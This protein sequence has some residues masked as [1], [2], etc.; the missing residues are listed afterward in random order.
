MP[1]VTPDPGP[2]PGKDSRDEPAPDLSVLIPVYNEAEN[3]GPLHDELTAVL[4][5]LPLRYELIFVDD[6]SSDG[7]SARLAGIQD[8][9]PERVRVAFLRR[10]YGQ[11]AA[12]SA[13]LDLARGDVLVPMDGDRQ[14]DP[15][16]IPRLLDRL[17]QGCE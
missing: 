5:D 7:T 16:D 13:A 3:V 11:T 1:S 6:G 2:G 9:D 15:A 10:N 14:N 17:N 8:A 4:R 12:L